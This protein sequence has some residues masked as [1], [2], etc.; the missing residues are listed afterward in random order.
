MSNPN[1]SGDL[2]ELRRLLDRLATVDPKCMPDVIADQ[3]VHGDP[4][5]RQKIEETIDRLPKRKKAS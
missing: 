5:T 1:S 2:D 3:W 4:G